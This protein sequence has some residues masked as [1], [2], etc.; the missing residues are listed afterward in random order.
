MLRGM[1]LGAQLGWGFGSILFLAVLL[2][3]IVG[4]SMRSVCAHSTQLANE[5]VPQ[6]TVANG[7]ER[8]LSAAMYTMRGYAL[9]GDPK[10]YD[11]TTKSFEGV[12]QSLTQA[13]KLAAG[14]ASLVQLGKAAKEAQASLA[15][16]RAAA[17]KTKAS[18]ESMDAALEG[19]AAT[20]KVFMDQSNGYLASQHEQMTSTATQGADAVL[21]RTGKIRRITDA[22]NLGMGIRVAVWR[23]VARRD[24][25]FIEGVMGNFEKIGALVDEV[26]GATRQEANAKQ[27]DAIKKAA[28]DYRTGL[29][30]VL[31][32]LGAQKANDALRLAAANRVKEQTTTTA[33]NG[34]KSMSETAKAATTALQRAR[35]GLILGLGI[36]LVLGA[37]LAV[38]MTRSITAP[39]QQAIDGLGRASRQVAQASGQLSEASQSMAAGASE[40]ASSLE[41]T[42][43][44]LEEMAAMTG[45]S[46]E[47]AQIASAKAGAAMGA[48]RSADA[49]M[50]RMADAM[51]AIRQSSNQ[52]AVILKTIDEIAFQTNLLALNAAVE[53]A[54]AGH[55]GKGFAVVAEEV[56]NLA[57]RSAEAAK[58]TATLIAESQSNAGL[59]VAAS[60]EVAGV[61]SEI[62]QTVT[63][64]TALANEVASAS[65][66]QATGI[67][68]INEAM[69]HMDQ[70]TQSNAA[71]A[72]ESASSS[73]ELNAQARELQEMV[74]MLDSVVHGAHGSQPALPAPA[75]GRAA[76]RPALAGAGQAK[77]LTAVAPPRNGVVASLDASDLD[78]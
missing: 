67:G 68:Q 59:G 70:V 61:L 26:R 62:G 9:T 22:L 16:Y 4:A 69:G 76:G 5:M 45:K 33:D 10:L 53:A 24:A 30:T 12:A 40:Q 11:D 52:T 31:E 14:R 41:E 56:R 36:V 43:A 57:H 75:L 19:L 29:S 6:V 58:S 18:V 47:N 8:S 23:S 72:E 17:E 7:A 66:E 38:G 32:A 73:E 35:L 60:E 25:S 13:E 44:S 42:S 50:G 48:A 39:I 78:F 54:R 3:V 46:A 65:R 64:V 74:A 27:L 63:Q 20:A 28:S 2:G 21:D 49:A 15:D 1:K 51:S 55:A 71:N 77:R 37:A 34:L